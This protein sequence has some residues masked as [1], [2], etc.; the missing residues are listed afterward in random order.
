MKVNILAFGI[1]K[2][3]VGARKGEMDF[4]EEASIAQVKDAL[5]ERFPKFEALRKFSIAVNEEYREDDYIIK[6][7]DELAIIPPVSG[8]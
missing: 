5:T 3:I 1:A 6:E 7:G 2:D 4:T 8:G